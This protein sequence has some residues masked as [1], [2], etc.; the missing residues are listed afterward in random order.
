[1]RVSAMVDKSADVCSHRNDRKPPYLHTPRYND[2]NPLPYPHIF[3]L[4]G[5]TF[6]TPIKKY[7]RLYLSDIF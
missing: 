6:Y 1:M 4:D 3:E 2:Q 7:S 5:V